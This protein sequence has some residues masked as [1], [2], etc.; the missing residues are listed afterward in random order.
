MRIF[1]LM[2]FVVMSASQLS[3][4]QMIGPKSKLTLAYC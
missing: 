3:V 2:V 1:D 4:W